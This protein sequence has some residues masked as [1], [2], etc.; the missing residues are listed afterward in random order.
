ADELVAQG[1][2]LRPAGD[3]D[4]RLGPHLDQVRVAA[5]RD[6]PEGGRLALP[7]RIGVVPPPGPRGPRP[8]APPLPVARPSRPAPAPRPAAPAA[9][10]ARTAPPG[11]AARLRRRAR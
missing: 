1:V 5:G 8:E 6:D 10:A 3:G 2:D 7:R 11:R 4:G 9:A